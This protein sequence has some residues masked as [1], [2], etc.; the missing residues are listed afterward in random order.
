MN[1]THLTRAHLTGGAPWRLGREERGGIAAVSGF[2]S[3]RSWWRH[4]DAVLARIRLLAGAT[5]LQK[6]PR[7]DDR[8]DDLL[9]VAMVSEPFIVPSRF[10]N[11]RE[12]EI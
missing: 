5:D 9:L 7:D 3:G 2:K 12:P 4:H 11:G 10:T 6:K 8:S 1:P